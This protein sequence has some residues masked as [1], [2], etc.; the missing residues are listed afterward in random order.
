MSLLEAEESLFKKTI[1]LVKSFRKL[2]VQN[3]GKRSL[4]DCL[5]VYQEEEILEKE[6]QKEE[7]TAN[8]KNLALHCWTEIDALLIEKYIRCFNLS[9]DLNIDCT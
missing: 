1:T 4:L 8:L 5:Y 2:N 3:V 6:N 7:R 9:H